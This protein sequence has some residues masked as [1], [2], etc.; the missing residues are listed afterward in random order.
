MVI[1][2]FGLACNGKNSYLNDGWNR[3]DL[4]VVTFSML[5]IALKDLPTLHVLRVVR[6]LRILRP[7]RLISRNN[8]LK[9]AYNA[10]MKSL[11]KILKMMLLTMFFIFV[12]S[13]I[14]IYLFSG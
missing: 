8:N 6:L 1:V 3:L 12:I 9:V 7:V 4:L 14:Q 2:T 10:L 11:P 5:D 13:M